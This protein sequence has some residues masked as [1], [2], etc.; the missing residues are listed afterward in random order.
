MVL[1]PHHRLRRPDVGGLADADGTDLVDIAGRVGLLVRLLPGGSAAA[2]HHREAAAAAGDDRGRLQ[3][4][5]RRQQPSG[6]I[7][8][9]DRLRC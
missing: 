1:P 3:C 9:K 7:S 5:L 8:G 6:R 2:R 4:A